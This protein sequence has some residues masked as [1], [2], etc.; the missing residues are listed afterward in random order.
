M[1]RYDFEFL[2]V[3]VIPKFIDGIY[4]SQQFSFYCA[5]I[6]FSITKRSASE[7]NRSLLPHVTYNY[8][9]Y[10]IYLKKPY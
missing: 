4:D 6:T 3:Q 5:I 8:N 9:T 1:I 7:M 10:E 2:A